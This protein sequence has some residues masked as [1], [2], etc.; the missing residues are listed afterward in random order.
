M[1]STQPKRLLLIEDNQGD[2]DLLRLGLLESHSQFGAS[3]DISCADR[4]ST[5]L[6]A[7]AK[8]RPAVVLLDLYL[9]DSRGAETFH[10]V[11]NQAQGVPVVVLSARDDEELVVDAVHHGVQDYLVKGTFDGR[12]LARTLKFAI[13]RHSL[14]TALDVNEKE[15]SQFKEQLLS[16]AL[17]DLR[18]PLTS[19]H[20]FVTTVLDDLA[21]PV[22]AGQHA[23]LDTVLC[24][25]NRLRSMIDDLIE[26]TWADSETMCVEP[27]CVTTGRRP[28][29]WVQQEAKTEQIRTD[30]CK[31]D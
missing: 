22:T 31:S 4:L 23:D 15:Q 27:P 18:I 30:Q 9:P 28:E 7:L 16:H 14:V 1:V 12:Q 6:A 19:I 2:I 29:M 25:V 5:G 10:N 26:R 21:A 8:E 17:H 3:Y 13:E 11:L 20:Q 24:C